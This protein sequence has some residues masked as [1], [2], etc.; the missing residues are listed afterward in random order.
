MTGGLKLINE[1]HYKMV[2]LT[3]CI[4]KV[5]YLDYKLKILIC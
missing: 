5:H 1:Y 2:I 4:Y 3:K